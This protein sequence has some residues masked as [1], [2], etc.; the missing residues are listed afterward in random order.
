VKHGHLLWGWAGTT[1]FG[2]IRTTVTDTAPPAPPLRIAPPPPGWQG[3]RSLPNGPTGLATASLVLGIVALV[4]NLFLIPTIL[5]IVF[6]VVSLARGT[7]GR[8]RAVVGIV[9]GAVGVL[10]ACIVAAIAIPV[11][12][13]VQHAAVASSMESSITTGAAQQGVTLTDVHCPVPRTV[14]A[15]A[16]TVCTATSSAGASLTAT[17]TF[18]ST[19]GAFTYR[20]APA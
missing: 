15:G 1:G 19:S 10:V 2:S 14:T 9:L 18:T 16:T 11:F 7:A 8:T 17:V 13:G 12:L 20:L 5:A 3:G 4:L 6:G